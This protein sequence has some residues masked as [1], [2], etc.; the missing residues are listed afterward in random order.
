M[1]LLATTIAAEPPSIAKTSGSCAVTRVGRESC[2]EA[3]LHAI[4]KQKL[5]LEMTK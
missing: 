1:S 5:I 4:Q 2:V 3:G